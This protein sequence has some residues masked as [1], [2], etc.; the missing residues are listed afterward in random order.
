MR[1]IADQR[2]LLARLDVRLL[3]R[4][5]RLLPVVAV[6]H[7]ARRLLHLGFA[8]GQFLVRD[9]DQLLGRVRDHLVLQFLQQSFPADRI[10][11]DR[12]FIIRS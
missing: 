10:A 1:K 8:P 2:R 7:F 5:K 11:D 9:L 6:T 12:R 3:D 4:F